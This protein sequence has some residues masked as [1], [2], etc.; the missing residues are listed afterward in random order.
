M[1]NFK[2][3]VLLLLFS[4]CNLSKE[5]YEKG[6]K[7]EQAGML[8]EAKDYYFKSLRED[9]DNID[10]RIALKKVGFRIISENMQDMKDQYSN[11]Q[12]KDAI[13]IYHKTL[14]FVTKSKSNGIDLSIDDR[15][16]TL[17]KDVVQNYCNELVGK[18]DKFMGQEEYSKARELYAEI[19][20]FKPDNNEVREKFNFCEK[21]PIYKRAVS[22]L[23]E[24]KYR[25]AYY[26]FD[27]ID[28]YRDARDLKKLAQK[29]AT[30]VIAFVQMD[31]NYDRNVLYLEKLQNKL[32]T[33][34]DPFVKFVISDKPLN[35]R[36]TEELLQVGVE[37]N[38]NTIFICKMNRLSISGTGLREKSKKGWEK[39]IIKSEGKWITRYK[40]IYY[41]ECKNQRTANLDISIT[42]ISTENKQ[43][44]FQNNVNTEVRDKIHYYEYKNPK[45]LR[46]GYWEDLYKDSPRDY[47]DRTNSFIGLLLNI[48]GI[49]ADDRIMK[50]INARKHLKSEQELIKK[51]VENNVNKTII[52]IMSY[53][54][55]K[56]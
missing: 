8:A 6:Q 34:K 29:K 27:Q 54:N 51:V 18:A 13:K 45:A 2:F 56:D 14:D 19:L 24:E 21:E 15:H 46:T 48:K 26:E 20:Q 9:K 35:F 32:L 4:A 1:K 43:I 30:R 38:A 22:Y 37:Y 28:D 7:L 25:K 52:K 42:L 12:Y 23:D 17:Y 36:S 50:M 16:A 3:F 40:K 41:R 47:I 49:S 10:A 55:A 31:Y 5:Y 53:Y 11:Q 39:Q 33:H 44:V